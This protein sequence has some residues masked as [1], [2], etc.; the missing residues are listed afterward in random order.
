MVFTVKFLITL[1]YQY[2]LQL[3]SF[4][5]TWLRLPCCA[6]AVR[7][8]GPGGAT[9]YRVYVDSGVVLLCLNAL[10]P[11][12]PLV[13]L[14][15]FFYFLTITPMLRRNMIFI[16]RPKFDA[17][18]I[19]WTFLFDMVISSMLVGQILLTTMMVLKTAVAPAVLAA[20][21]FVPTIMFR[22]S[23]RERYL[24]AFNDVALLQTSLLDGWDH[25]DEGSTMEKREEFRRFLVDAH[26]A[27]YVP[28][29]IAGVHT[30]SVITSEPAVVVPTMHDVSAS[31]SP[32]G[33]PPLPENP[34]S[35]PEMPARMPLRERF[36][37]HDSTNTVRR[38]TK[39]Q[40]GATLRRSIR[41][42]RGSGAVVDQI[43]RM[44]VNEDGSIYFDLTQV[45]DNE[46]LNCDKRK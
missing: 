35:D 30:D 38:A 36:N 28:V 14:C 45:A 33:M 23:M 31:T 20:I 2:M 41:S 7:G 39:S 22:D 26:K 34:E 11:A 25:Q 46:S 42:P 40:V 6:R 32:M 10:A 15:A 8:G 17:G 21:P 44:A 9:P 18:G 27:A 37:S 1:P 13:A 12:S 5:L 19:R 4:L 29:C 43:D 24:Q 16:Y 3:N